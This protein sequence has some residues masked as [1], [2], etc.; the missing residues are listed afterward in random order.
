MTKAQVRFEGGR[1][2]SLE[3]R[4]H[5]GYAESGEDIVCSAISLLTITCGNA[6]ESILGVKPIE[7]MNE[8][9]AMIHIALPQG[10]DEQQEHDAQ[11]IFRTVLQGMEDLQ[12]NYPKNFHLTKFDG[13]QIP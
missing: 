12:A 11:I 1:I 5:A 4:G 3:V 7:E 10:L 6:L 8:N 2:V 9:K 13:R